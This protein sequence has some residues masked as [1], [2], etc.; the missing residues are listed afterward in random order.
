VRLRD[1][2]ITG[3]DGY[4]TRAVNGIDAWVV[5]CH[6]VLLRMGS[7]MGWTIGTL[8]LNWENDQ[9]LAHNCLLAMSC[10]VHG[11]TDV[12]TACMMDLLAT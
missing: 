1:G 10:G 2:E 8:L 11:R 7:R 6:G 5:A 12:Q 9:R 4:H 3:V